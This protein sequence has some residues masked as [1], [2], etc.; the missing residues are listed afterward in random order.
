MTTPARTFNE[1]PLGILSPKFV[2]PS[3][4]SGAVNLH[5][6]QSKGS[7]LL[8]FSDGLFRRANETTDNLLALADRL[9]DF[10]RAAV[11]IVV[12]SRDEYPAAAADA[13][14]A[15]YDSGISL[16]LDRDAEVGRLYG[17]HCVEPHFG[18]NYGYDQGPLLCLID[19]S[20]IIRLHTEVARISSNDPP[21]RLTA[22]EIQS[23]QLIWEAGFPPRPI[24]VE[25]L[26]HLGQV[27]FSLANKSVA[28]RK[29]IE[30]HLE[31][32]VIE[33]GEQKLADLRNRLRIVEKPLEPFPSPELRLPGAGKSKTDDSTQSFDNQVPPDR[34]YEVMGHDTRIVVPEEYAIELDLV[35]QVRL[36][37]EAGASRLESLPPQ[38]RMVTRALPEHFVAALDCL[39]D[40]RLIQRLLLLNHAS[41]NEQEFGRM[42]GDPNLVVLATAHET[43]D[44]MF[45]RCN[46]TS[47]L[48]SDLTHE[49]AHLVK[50]DRPLESEMFRLTEE[51]EKF[52][53]HARDRAFVNNE[54][55]FAVHLGEE[56]LHTD[57]ARLELL[58]AKAPLRTMVMGQALAAVLRHTALPRS[59]ACEAAIQRAVWV[60]D[61]VRPRGVDLLVAMARSDAGTPIAECADSEHVAHQAA[62]LLVYLGEGRR[63]RNAVRG[64]EAISFSRSRCFNYSSI[65]AMEGWTWLRTL[66]LTGTFGARSPM[67]NPLGMI[68]QLETLILNHSDLRAGPCRDLCKVPTLKRLEVRGTLLDDGACVY[69]G[70]MTG[71]TYLDLRHTGITS[72]GVEY[73]RSHLPGAEIVFE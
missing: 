54:E 3:Y 45:Y 17:C 43:G 22:F 11:R 9:D 26:L 47:K 37:I 63:L 51:L 66:D 30:T 27:A 70:T 2:L 12:V 1:F 60:M 34:V 23:Q 31:S 55:N 72:R 49:W 73:L 67:L 28:R 20:G 69:I 61:H 40:S 10:D 18:R 59:P 15:K 16:L 57:F 56:M 71:L 14:L 8:Y 21:R 13:F 41:P 58:A 44:V 53:Y 39:P 36:A 33:A 46:R 38:P 65:A 52:G 64:P 19:P 62:E 68:G 24:S 4:P 7:V 35:C 48:L 50:Y 42:A 32:I 25:F 29:A 5:D 6:F